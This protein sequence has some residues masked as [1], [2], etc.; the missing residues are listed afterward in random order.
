[1]DTTASINQPAEYQYRMQGMNAIYFYSYFS[2]I[3]FRIHSFVS[4]TTI[5]SFIYTLL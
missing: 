3:F 4:H 1:V 2:F 5:K